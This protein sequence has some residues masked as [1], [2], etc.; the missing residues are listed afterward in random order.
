MSW[1]YQEFVAADVNL[2]GSLDVLDV[3][4]LVNAVLGT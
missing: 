3:V 4:A 2:D 1:D